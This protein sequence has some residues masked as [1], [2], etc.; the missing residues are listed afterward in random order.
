MLFKETG[1][2]E[3]PTVILLHGGGLSCWALTG[4][5][6]LLQADYHVVTPIIH[7]Y[8]ENSSNDFFSIEDSANKIFNN[9]SL[10]YFE[11]LRLPG[12]VSATPALQSWHSSGSQD[13]VSR[14]SS[15]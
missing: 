6:E 9:A 12:A 2:S 11:R 7:G 10:A 5:V 1:N 3:L 14:R 15:G 13:G 4:I 8:G